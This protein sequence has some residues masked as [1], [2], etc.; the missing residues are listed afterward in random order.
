M[1]GIWKINA[2]LEAEVARLR[3][4]LPPIYTAEIRSPAR[5]FVDAAG[6]P[7]PAPPPPRIH[8]YRPAKVWGAWPL[9]YR[10]DGQQ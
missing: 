1:I 7:V 5:P 3:D 2:D 6:N 10:W 9:P 4:E 8:I